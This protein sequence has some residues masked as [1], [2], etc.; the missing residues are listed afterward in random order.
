[1]MTLSIILMNINEDIVSLFHCHTKITLIYINT[2]VLSLFSSLDTCPTEDTLADD[3][4]ISY[5]SSEESSSMVEMERGTDSSRWNSRLVKLHVYFKHR[6]VWFLWQL[7]L[8]ILYMYSFSNY[9][10]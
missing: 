1:M 3:K 9:L 5:D 10:L 2:R 4:N 6:N 8:D 7:C